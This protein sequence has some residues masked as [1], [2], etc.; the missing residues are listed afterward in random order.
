ML[1]LYLETNM[2]PSKWFE[3]HPPKPIIE[4]LQIFDID[5]DRDFLRERIKLRTHKMI[6]IGLLDEV[7]ILEKKYGREPNSMKAIGIIEV[8]EYFDGVHSK[9]EMIELISIHTAQLAKRQ[10]T[11]NKNQ[12]KDRVF[13]DVGTLYKKGVEFFATS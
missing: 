13:A 5:I 1:H 7:K 8:L 3:H 11:F 9:D 2:A 4:N 6:D 10:R 12:F